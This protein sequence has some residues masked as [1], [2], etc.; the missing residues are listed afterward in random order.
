MKV[1]RAPVW[2]PR[3][4]GGSGRLHRLRR[5]AA[6]A[7][8]AA[9]LAAMLL[10]GALRLLGGLEPARAQDGRRYVDDQAGCSGQSP[11]HASIQAA[12]D[13]ASPGE[14]IEVAPGRYTETVQVVDKSLRFEGPGADAGDPAGDPDQHAIWV[15][16]QGGLPGVALIADARTADLDGLHVEGFR[17]E[18]AAAGLLLHGRQPGDPLGAWPGL[19]ATVITSPTRLRD[20]R[21]LAN[22]FSEIGGGS[23]PES[24][25]VVAWFVEDLDIE[26]NHMHRVD[27]GLL[28]RGGQ[29]LRVADNRLD[30]VGGPGI[31]LRGLGGLL[32]L[33]DN[34]LV[35]I[36]GRGIEVLDPPAGLP[37]ASAERLDL[38][39]NRIESADAEALRLQ[40]GTGQALQRLRLENNRVTGAGAGAVSLAG[41]VTILDGSGSI[42]S[43]EIVG[44]EI[45]DTQVPGAAG[46][47]IEGVTR[48][49][50]LASLRITGGSGPGLRLIDARSLWLHRSV[51]T[52]NAEALRIVE[53][54]LSDPGQPFDLRLGGFASEGNLLWGNGA[55]LVLEND[56]NP[57]RTHDIDARHND[58]GVAWAPQ[59][60]QR[61]VHQPDAM[62]LGLVSYLPALGMPA[63]V[64]LDAQPAILEADGVSTSTLTARVFDSAGRSAADGA[65]VRFET[66]GGS[67]DRSGQEAEV[68]DAAAVWR[69]D[70]WTL[71]EDARYGLASSLGY[72]RASAAGAVFSW[73]FEAPAV[74]LRYGQSP[75]DP[76][77]FRAYVDDQ[78]VADIQARGPRREWVEQPLAVGL[79]AGLHVLRVE[80]LGG[81]AAFDRLLSGQVLAAGRARAVLRAADVP[82][83]GRVN[84]EAYGAG[85]RVAGQVEVPF[86]S[87]PPASM[88]LTVDDEL[89]TV[90]GSSTR[91]V[92][93]ISDGEGRPVRDGTP[94]RFS[95]QGGGIAPMDSATRDGRAEATFTSGDRAGPA[96][97]LASIDPLTVTRGITLLPGAAAR[98][99]MT[100]TRSSLPA[101][102]QTASSLVV[103]AADA[104]GNPV[105]DGSPV[106][107]TT[108]LGRLEA[109]RLQTLGG[110][111]ETRLVAG[112]QIGQATLRAVAGSGEVTASVA[113][114]PTDLRLEQLAEPRSAVV[115]GERVSFT[116]RL[117]NV[118]AGTIF[119]VDLVD[120]LP[121]G[122]ISPSFRADFLPRGP[123]LEN[124]SGGEPYAFRI[125]RMP[126]GQQGL[127][128]ITARLDTSLGWGSD[129][130]LVNRASASSA[131]AYEAT[132]EDN[133]ATAE[134]EVSPG[135][136]FTVTVEAPA[137]LEVGG[138]EAEVVARVL[139]R[140]GNPAVD[141]TAVFFTADDPEIASLS[142][143]VAS[144]RDG[145]ARSTLRTGLRA[146]DTVIRALSIDDRGGSARLKVLPGPAEQLSLEASRRAIAIGGQ[147]A[148][149]TATLRD[150]FGNAVPEAATSFETDAGLLA[151]TEAR[152][153][154]RGVAT[155]SLRS[156]IRVG[157]AT[158]RASH[159]ELIDEIQVDFEP[160]APASLMLE[161]ADHSLVVGARTL[162]V[163]RIE[164][165][166]GNPV[167]GISIEMDSN[168]AGL[169]RRLHVSDAN[170]QAEAEI[171][172][173]RPGLGTVSARSRE[174]RAES[175]LEV[176]PR[177]IWLPFL[178]HR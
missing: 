18:G 17:F 10:G 8:L 3:R 27:A 137:R 76:G 150:A 110:R 44:D 131:T 24:A 153:D 25:A 42:G 173:L 36:A 43:L 157:P 45:V 83:R 94:L 118:G 65:L 64:V 97:V 155:S 92:A 178:A 35:E 62:D 168:I 161:L 5:G 84:A 46:L 30:E 146:G 48:T 98:L 51:I 85:G 176:F 33:E 90:G 140:L 61:L 67:L 60:E 26:G 164:D 72:L 96:L 7:G 103:D 31:E 88:T 148:A 23:P 114:L 105:A 149:L 16:S 100:P 145:I 74:V 82:G 22:R 86:V 108:S 2:Q 91:V 166:F 119:D 20:V 55:A 120:R 102:S 138:E 81:E 12:V 47:H 21:V 117:R 37:A 162:A 15:G 121:A 54:A 77:R 59:I 70:R 159:E 177:R 9:L 73:T 56:G 133:A 112:N 1:R 41:G 169:D 66:N 50:D 174:L 142:P 156:G 139:D 123:L 128:T 19:P 154:A 143:A 89:L 29:G 57:G 144:T 95:A 71:M 40:A 172:A 125:D 113:L 111:A 136:A 68:E 124:R 167:S 63:D 158:V 6:R 151:I 34:Q 52:G 78:L 104:Y 122:L 130:R 141:G 163:A 58:W 11:C 39:R 127:V 134:I 101:N 87:G 99:H 147:T 135:A 80:V 75:I 32:R 107:L 171:V 93:R 13:A 49:L 4:I 69:S 165:A 28:S 129:S 175:R 152:T 132:P 126:A 170:G 160:G 116:L 106:L 38:V 53:T 79:G 109:E 115:P 14:T